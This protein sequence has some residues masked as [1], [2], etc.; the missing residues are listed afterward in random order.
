MDNKEINGVEFAFGPAWA[1][2]SPEKWIASETSQRQHSKSK[3]EWQMAPGKAKSS[4]RFGNRNRNE[5]SAGDFASR[6]KTPRP[7]ATDKTDTRQPSPAV[8]PAITVS[9]IPERSG[10]KPLVKQLASTR[11]AYSIFEVAAT[12]LS[13]P[14]FYAAAIESAGNDGLPALPLYQCA[15]CKAVFTSKQTAVAHGLKRHLNMFYDKEEKE[16]E[17]PQGKFACV[18]R[19]TLSGELL[20]PPNYHAFNEKLAELYRS[21]FAG[22]PLDQYRKKIV[23]ET[24][25]ALI[26]QWK[27]EAARKTIYRT[28]LLNEQVVFERISLLEQHFNENY[29]PAL[30][31]ESRRFIIP[32]KISQEMDDHHIQQVIQEAW[33]K[34]TRFPIN[35][36]IAIQKRFRHLGLHIFRTSA[37]MT[38]VSSVRPHA[39]DPAQAT[40]I[41]RNILEWIKT[42]TG[43]TRQN[44]AAAL[45]PGVTSDSA[46]VAEI[47]NSL[48]WLIDRGHV[49]EFRNG[50]LAVPNRASPVVRQPGLRQRLCRGESAC[51]RANVPN[52]ESKAKSSSTGLKPSDNGLEEA[53]NQKLELEPKPANPALDDRKN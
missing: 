6:R 9:F 17:L 28:K 26:E 53:L 42:N 37:K 44:L 23:N 8:L 41:V 46:G 32:A 36:A 51:F 43:K 18:A 35:M 13:K 11:R 21:R 47:I 34:E 50:T 5:K 15:E 16:G 1:R 52:E 10:L 2:K 48:V 45:A 40:D 30:I 22:M 4:A 31:R 19:C 14:E 7:A 38:F 49:I 20:G 25:P 33:Q 24:D 29:A 3:R 27:K 12:F 39:I